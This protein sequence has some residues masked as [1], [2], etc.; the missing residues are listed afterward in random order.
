MEG[1]ASPE[2]ERGLG[3]GACLG[4]KWDLVREVGANSGR[5]RKRGVCFEWGFIQGTG[6]PGKVFGWE[7]CDQHAN[8]AR[9]PS[10]WPENL[11]ETPAPRWAPGLLSEARGAKLWS[12]KTEQGEDPTSHTQVRGKD[13]RNRPE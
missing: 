3:H 7:E 2:V 10:T 12:R 1:T 9:K 6:K 5:C 8:V 13:A 4:R 11:L